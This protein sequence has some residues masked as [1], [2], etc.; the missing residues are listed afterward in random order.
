[1]DNEYYCNENFHS[2]LIFFLIALC[3]PT[4]LKNLLSLVIF[5]LDFDQSQKIC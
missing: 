5:D 2:L 1:M 4:D 3:S